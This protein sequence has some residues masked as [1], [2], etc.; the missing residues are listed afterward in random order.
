[1]EPLVSD[2]K[3]VSSISE[4]KKNYRPFSQFDYS[5][6]DGRFTDKTI[7]NQNHMVD[8]EHDS[9]SRDV[10]HENSSDND[11]WYKEVIELRKKAEEYKVFYHVYNVLSP[12]KNVR[13]ILKNFFDN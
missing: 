4:Y 10:S 12:F 1:M 11:S 5:E 2:E 8:D 7:T 3:H 13:N 9:T 6:N